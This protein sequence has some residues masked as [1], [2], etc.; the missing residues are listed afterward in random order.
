MED[1][2]LDGFQIV[3]TVEKDNGGSIL[4][5][6]RVVLGLTQ[7]QVAEKAKVP[8]ASYQ[9]F[10]S[11]E[12]NICTASF[13]LACRVVLFAVTRL[14]AS[15]LPFEY[16]F[17]F[18]HTWIPPNNAFADCSS[19]CAAVRIFTVNYEFWHHKSICIS[20][21]DAKNGKT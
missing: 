1:F 21:Y 12:R 8:L 17:T 15:I 16:V 6:K 19:D 5:E 18:S 10:E 20:D 3:H 7:K 9:R 4:R 13:Q 2:K 14:P 11:G